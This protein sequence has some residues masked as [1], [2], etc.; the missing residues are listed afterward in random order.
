MEK[1]DT[2]RLRSLAV[3]GLVVIASLAFCILLLEFIVFRFFLV[4]PDFPKL[5]FVDNVLKYKPGQQGVYRVKNEIESTFNINED[6]WN[7]RYDQYM[8]D[9]DPATFRIAIIGDSYVEAL[10]VDYNRSLAERLEEQTENGRLQVYRF[11]ISGAALSQYLHILRREVLRYTPDLVVIVLVHNDFHESYL[12]TPGLYTNSFL[13]IRTAKDTI[14]GELQPLKYQQP[15]YSFVRES[16]TWRYLAYRQ[17]VHFGLLR[18]VIFQAGKVDKKRYEANIDVTELNKMGL[19]NRLVTE[20]VFERL[21]EVCS[22]NGMELLVVMD[23]ARN[24]IYTDVDQEHDY[25]NN[26]LML[27]KMVREVADKY[28]ISFIDLHRV[29]EE[30]FTINQK[31]FDFKCD[32]HWNDY[33]HQVVAEAIGNFI[34]EKKWIQND[35]ALVMP[36]QIRKV[37]DSENVR[38]DNAGP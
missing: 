2:N 36:S 37:Q 8:V 22:K 27:N 3:N 17:Q 24:G 1:A 6:G 14:R 21:K 34:R 20:Y 19:K 18:D 7:S 15:W 10:Q 11:G 9:K 26:A 35:N 29:F 4:A 23:G 5:D 12:P 31:K 33:G 30:D 28:D 25:S 13:R 32:G 16:A 38:S